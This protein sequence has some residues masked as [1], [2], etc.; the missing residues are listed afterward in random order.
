MIDKDRSWPLSKQKMEPSKE[1]E[2]E[3]LRNLRDADLLDLTRAKERLAASQREVERL[4]RSNAAHRRE[5]HAIRAERD[6]LQAE[7]AALKSRAIVTA[8]DGDRYVIQEDLERWQA[9]TKTELDTLQ[10]ELDAAVGLLKQAK[11]MWDANDGQLCTHYPNGYKWKHIID[12]F[13]ASR[14]EGS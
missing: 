4:N 1:A 10:D 6:R 11:D 2:I 3:K 7:N 13:L 14:K 5:H 9:H 8:T 12:T